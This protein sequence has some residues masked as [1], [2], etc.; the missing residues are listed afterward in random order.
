MQIHSA[1][2]GEV[3]LFGFGLLN[4][5]LEVRGVSEHSKV[6]LGYVRKYTHAHACYFG[7]LFLVQF[8]IRTDQCR[9]DHTVSD[10]RK[11]QKMQVYQKAQRV[12][13]RLIAA[14]E[15]C[16]QAKE[17][18]SKRK[19]EID[20]MITRHR[21]SCFAAQGSGVLVC[22]F[23]FRVWDLGLGLAHVAYSLMPSGTGNL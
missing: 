4:V 14:D 19:N 2:L 20:D 23:G 21:L 3:F 8:N 17:T 11:L 5:C 18:I 12:V 7:L 6:L 22:G 9:I 15:A 16:T 13:L 1:E 10:Q